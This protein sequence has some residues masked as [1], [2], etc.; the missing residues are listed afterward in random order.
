MAFKRTIFDRVGAFLFIIF[1][2]QS[3]LKTHTKLHLLE[4]MKRLIQQ[5]ENMS[6]IRSAFSSPG[7]SRL[8]CLDSNGRGKKRSVP[9]S[10]YL[11]RLMWWEV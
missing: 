4:I 8:T 1:P 2:L 11:I 5:I 7:R 10:K 6:A 3:S 9:E